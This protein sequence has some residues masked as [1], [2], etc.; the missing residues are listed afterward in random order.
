MRPRALPTGDTRPA[1]IRPR[2]AAI[3]TEQTVVARQHSLALLLEPSE[4]WIGVHLP[5]LAVEAVWA[6][7]GASPRAVVELQAQKQTVAAMGES[8][9]KLGIRVGMSMGAALALVPSLETSPRAPRREGQLLERLAAHAQRFTPRVSLAPPDGL[10]LEVKGSLH[11]F[12]GAEALCR[13]LEAEY[14]SA[15]VT[16][17]LALAP[18]PLAALAVARAG[19]SLIVTERAHLVGQLA[20]LPLATLRWPLQVLERLVQIGVRT[21]GEARRLPRAGFARRFG[22]AQLDMLDRLTG[23][24]TDVRARFQVRE[25]FH[26]R[27]ELLYEIEHH[28]ALLE[29][30]APLL[31]ELGKFLSSRQRG[32]TRLECLLQHRHAPPTRC[33]LRLATP[34]AG[35]RRLTTLLGEQ[36]ARLSLPEPVRACEL[37]SGRLVPR[38][39]ASD[40]LWQAG[41]HGGGAAA[42]SDGLIEHL[43]ARLGAEAVYGLQ[44]LAGHR[45]ETAWRSAS[46]G[47][48]SGPKTP[49]WPAFRRPLWL[50][51]APHLLLEREGL[52]HRRGPLRLLD[53]PER[54]ETGW[55]DGGDIARDYYTALDIRGVRLWI[56]RERARPHR[57]FVQG[58]FG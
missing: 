14:R 32:I 5:W 35:V 36:L 21:I 13:A 40:S 3:S 22:K 28:A 11:L 26:R 2:G 50:L 24:D 23:R 44:L 48:I 51:P 7:S 45:P 46:P 47:V 54:V 30:L 8:A 10:L 53:G 9:R 20:S 19:K 42:E 33:V 6:D 37:R 31:Q 57:W 38:A 25:R 4:L 55:W 15:G 29:A 52:P 58:V 18:T 12:R 41:E 16:P 56:F 39:F 17:V 43:R 34:A 27:R 1:A 49:A